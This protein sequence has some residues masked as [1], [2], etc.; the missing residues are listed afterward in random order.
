NPGALGTD[1]VYDR[2]MWS[3][4]NPV[5]IVRAALTGDAEVS[6]LREEDGYQ[7][8]DLT[9]DVGTIALAVD[10]RGF[11]HH[12]DWSTAH[13]NLGEVVYTTNFVG[14]TVFDG[15]QLPM[16]TTTFLDWRNV[17]FKAT[18]ADGWIVNGEVADLAAPE[19]IV[20]AN[21]PVPGVAPLEIEQIADRIWRISNG[22]SVI[23]F[24]DHLSI[25]ELN[26]NQLTAQAILDLAQSV[27]PDKPLTELI[28]SHHHFDHTSGVRVGVAA[29]LTII[30]DAG[31]EDIF[32]DM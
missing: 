10:D 9:V 12:V 16:G 22:T 18:Y 32:R 24:D 1:G 2:R 27:N 23:E 21:V 31:S 13:Q 3:L 14:Y 19:Q 26:G 25:Y 17:M 8:V 15:I 6:N 28:Y 20:A 4:T 30:A 7:V 5:A 29:G 11:P